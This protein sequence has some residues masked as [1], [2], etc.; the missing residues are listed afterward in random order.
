MYR[1]R[2]RDNSEDLE[3]QFLWVA[4]KMLVIVALFFGYWICNAVL[5]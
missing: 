4:I 2:R 3:D 1:K 5:G